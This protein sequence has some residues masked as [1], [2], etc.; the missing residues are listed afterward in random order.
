[1]ITRLNGFIENWLRL[2]HFGPVLWRDGWFI[3][4]AVLFAGSELA[5]IVA[6]SWLG[7]L[8]SVFIFYWVGWVRHLASW[9]VARRAKARTSAV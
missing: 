8:T 4:A 3:T 5:C 9:L 6:R 2:D 1:M 7:L